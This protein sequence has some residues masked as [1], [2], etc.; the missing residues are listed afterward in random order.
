VTR[1][2][3]NP[4]TYSY[5]PDVTKK[6]L[7][8]TAGLGYVYTPE[9][10]PRVIRTKYTPYSGAGLLENGG[11]CQPMFVPEMW[12]CVKGRFVLYREEEIEWLEAFLESCK[13]MSGMSEVR[14][15]TTETVAQMWERKSSL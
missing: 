11:L 14:W 5:P 15:S 6:I 2:T 13:F 1:E 3:P 7:K 8:T 9:A 10:L 4:T 12:P